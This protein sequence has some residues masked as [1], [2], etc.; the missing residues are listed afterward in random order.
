[1]G[2]Y[3]FS[4]ELLSE[5][6]PEDHADVSSGHD[7]GHD[8]IPALLERAKVYGYG[9]GGQSGRVSQDRYWRDVGTLDG[10]YE[11]NME[12]LD[13]MPSLDLYQPEWPIR[14]YQ[15]QR[16]P[17]RT[18]PG[19]HGTEGIFINSIA[20][21]GVVISGAG[22]QHSI[23]FPN[24][25]VRE[26]S[27]VHDSILFDGVVV[28][29]GTQ[30]NRCVVDKGVQIPPGEQIGMDAAADAKRFT[31]TPKGVVIVPKGYVFL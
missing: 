29:K 9:F 20:A 5:Y 6:L 24:V 2:I 15:S 21:G 13:P 27:M 16:P 26:N 11:A 1:M 30:L 17:S 25:R 14:T 23:I 4:M 19:A 18:V 12:L 3:V 31:V 7:F 10:Y 28:G 22:V 8:V